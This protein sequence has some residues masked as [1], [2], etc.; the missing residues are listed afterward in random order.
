[1]ARKEAALSTCSITQMTN[2]KYFFGWTPDEEAAL[3]SDAHDIMMVIAKRLN[4]A[5]FIVQ[6][7]HCIIHDRDTREVWDDSISSYVLETKP[8][9]FHMI[10][11]FYRDAKTKTIHSGTL[12]KIADAV[13]VEP[14]YIEK[15]GKGC[16][17]WDNMLSYL[18]H[19]K[20]INKAQYEP[21]EVSTAGA[22]LN[23]VNI[24]QPYM[25]IY[26]QRK[27]DWELGRTKVTIKQA[28]VD[29]DGLEEKILL[30]EVK[31]NQVLLT[32]SLF[33][34]YAH[35][36]RRLDDAF[37]I[38]ADRKIA[39]TIQAME[40][41]GFLL[42]VL[43]V[44]GKSHS[45]KSYFT[46]YLVKRIH[47]DAKRLYGED[48]TVCTCAASNPFDEYRGEEIL[49]M[50]DLRGMAMTASDWLKLLDPDRVNLASARYHNR[51]IACRVIIINSE[52]D[53]ADFFYFVKGRGEVSESMDQFIRRI[54]A[55]VV[56]YRVPDYEDVRRIK[57]GNMQ[58]TAPYKLPAPS[59][60]GGDLTLHHDF[61]KDEMDLSYQEGL[62]YLSD[63]VMRRN[64]PG[65]VKKVV[66][67][68][69][70]PEEMA[71][72]LDKDITATEER[73][74]IADEEE[75]DARAKAEEDALEEALAAHERW[76]ARQY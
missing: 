32:D 40:S 73:K 69:L 74:R 5:G 67:R 52:R 50:D 70:T 19:I 31:R 9:H 17:A 12:A 66:P 71:D 34:I 46:D 3:S 7:T 6:E 2:P 8:R 60:M 56:V 37:D 4:N 21:S 62:A 39:K 48:W 16:H 23:G 64:Q 54:M 15:A 27:R 68:D 25:D 24:F 65:I 43:Y 59:A 51:R 44:T 10:V 28:S 30:G 41:G 57:I 61:K 20:Y 58:E 1:M 55:R 75:I 42:S 13:G 22:C 29:V 47:D 45:G 53:V 76:K 11:K 49:V 14:Q 18:I 63:A 72:V 36:K 35:N 38:Y 33:A 26:R